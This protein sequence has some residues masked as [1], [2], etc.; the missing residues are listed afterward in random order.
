MNKRGF[1]LVWNN[2]VLMILGIIL[3]IFIL[4]FFTGFSG[5]FLIKIKSYFSASNVD[6]IVDGCNILV[7]S[8]SG[9]SYCCE[10]KEVVYF[11]D[12]KKAKGNY[13]CK[14]LSEMDFI[15][16]KIKIL[17]CGSVKC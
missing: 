1:E 5:D 11:K 13:S 10:K 6:S 15:S 17:D 14:E 8:N 9:Y 12:N 2:V 7:D 3:L 4:L 16:G